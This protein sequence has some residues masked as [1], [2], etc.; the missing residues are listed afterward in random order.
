[1]R[2]LIV[3]DEAPGR[4]NVRLALAEHA[5]WQVVGEC[6]SA[7]AARSALAAGGIDLVFLD[8]QM[9][10]ASGL[11]L[12]RELCETAAPPLIVFVTAYDRYAIEAFDVHALD[13]LLKPFDDQRFAQTLARAQAMLEQKQQAGYAQA[14]RICLD[15]AEGQPGG[16]YARHLSIRSVGRIERV[17]MDEILWLEAAGN[18][19]QLHLAQRQVLHR[20]PLSRLEQMLDPA[21]F[22]R[23]HRGAI[24][25][26]EECARFSA[27][28]EGGGILHLR[29]G[30]QVAV[31]ERY[32]PALRGLFA[33]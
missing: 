25:R 3:D 11:A 31:S 15:G 29:C 2:A 26:R 21:Q 1:M 24:V 7:E 22:L 28:G 23:V 19:V 5:Q 14:V 6:D 4:S 16:G 9:P 32:L 27:T 8:I 20:M 12:A 33:A 17:E 13:Y 10:G 18:Y 30:A